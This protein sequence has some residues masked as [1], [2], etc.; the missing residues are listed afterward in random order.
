M[1][2]EQILGPEQADAGRA[3]LLGGLGVGQVVDVGEQLDLSAVGALGGEVAI[4]DQP[5]LEIEEFALDL[6]IGRGRLL[7]GPNDDHAV[8]AVDDHQVAALDLAHDPLDARDGRD[9]A[10]PCQDRRV[11]GR[12]AKLGDDARRSA[13]R[14]GS[15]PGWAGS[16]VPPGSP[17]RRRCGTH[18]PRSV[19]PNSSAG[20]V[21]LDPQDHVAD[22]GHP[23]AKEILLDPRELRRVAVHHDL[24]RR[25]RRQLLFLDQTA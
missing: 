3:D 21:R 18:R 14:R 13:G 25:Q 11:A 23:L 7:I 10:A 1:G 19:W 16:R 22:V 2:E 12:P 20:Q 6:A 4:G 24:K 8:A 5:V 17:I 15:S 9:A